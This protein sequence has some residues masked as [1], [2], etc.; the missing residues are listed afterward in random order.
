MLKM[1]L[2]AQLKIMS[3]NWKAYICFKRIKNF[4]WVICI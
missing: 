2:G 3:K 1:I 4:F